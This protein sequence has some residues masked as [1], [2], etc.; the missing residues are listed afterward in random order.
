MNE[1]IMVSAEDVSFRYGN[2]QALYGVSLQCQS[3][4]I[5]A[6]AGPNG[7]GK[8]TLFKLL[9][10]LLPPQQ[11]KLHVAGHELPAQAPIARKKLG[12]VFQ[13]P[14]LDA[15]LTVS[16][17]LHFA[18]NFYGLSGQPLRERVLQSAKA[19]HIADRLNHKVETLSGG[20]RRRVEIA[21]AL[22]PQPQLLLMDEPSTGLDPM[23]RTACWEIYKGLRKQGLCVLLTTHFLE[24]AAEA[25]AV[26]MLHKGRLVAYGTPGELC[27]ALGDKILSVRC[28][29]PELVRDWLRNNPKVGETF[30][31]M[32]EVRAKAD[33]PAL[34][35][36]QLYE[37]P[38][39][40][41]SSATISLPALGD[42]F[43]KHAGITFAEA[44]KAAESSAQ[45]PNHKT[46][47]RG[48]QN[49]LKH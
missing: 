39:F 41:V 14:A 18:G 37:R 8:S 16:E 6:L 42:V 2:H 33:D 7:G 47:S 28:A 4:R 5:F 27:R 49:N 29:N 19:T 21:R 12:V 43:A 22:L 34:L 30:M 1:Q 35:A 9:A 46:A 10:T 36:R 31:L 25:D 15:K 13:N 26:A 24:E 20:L 45:E 17:N 11:G 23:A 48:P 40:G 3:G 44:E 32:G 38:E